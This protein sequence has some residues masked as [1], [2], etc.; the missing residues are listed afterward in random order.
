MPWINRETVRK[1]L[2]EDLK[3]KNVCFNFV[4]RL[5][6]PDQNLLRAES[7]VEFVA[8][9]DDDRNVLKTM[10]TGDES[11]YFTFD[12]ETKRQNATWL[13]L[14][15]PKTQKVRMQKSRLKAMLTAFFYVKD[16][17]HHE[18]MS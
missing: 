13:S 3:K 14:K 15:E 12:L 7:S 11:W 1:I 5:L 16:T 8:T 10:I 9:I 18:F 6:K 17:I 2:V 4:P